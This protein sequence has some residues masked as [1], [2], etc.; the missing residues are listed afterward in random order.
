MSKQLEILHAHRVILIG[1]YD[2]TVFSDKTH[3]QY[4]YYSKYLVMLFLL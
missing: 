1:Q 3:I 4:D 2:A